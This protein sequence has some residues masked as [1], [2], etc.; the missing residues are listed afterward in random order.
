MGNADTVILKNGRSATLTEAGWEVM[1]WSTDK[2][3]LVFDSIGQLDRWAET[4]DQYGRM[5]QPLGTAA[6][7]RKF[8]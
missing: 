2:H 5:T 1:P 4:H 6:A 7:G 8:R 3:P